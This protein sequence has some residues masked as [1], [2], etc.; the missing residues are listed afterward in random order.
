[1]EVGAAARYLGANG[2]VEARQPGPVRRRKSNG[3]ISICQVI[4]IPDQ[5]YINHG[6]AH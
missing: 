3:P 6:H 5:A 4:V 1:M 2:I